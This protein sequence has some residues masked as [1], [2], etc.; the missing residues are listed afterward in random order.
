MSQSHS[1]FLAHIERPR[2]KSGSLIIAQTHGQGFMLRKKRSVEL[3]SGTQ[4]AVSFVEQ[5]YGP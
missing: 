5:D 4:T 3:L 1:I 2:A